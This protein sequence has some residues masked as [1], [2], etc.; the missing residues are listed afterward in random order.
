MSLA[1]TPK[2]IGNIVRNARKKKGWSQAELGQ[3][4]GIRQGTVSL[5]ETGNPA[6]KLSTILAVLSVLDLEFKIGDRSKGQAAD[7]GDVF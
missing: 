5:I 1:R 3:K 6:T 2:T 7:I 4:V